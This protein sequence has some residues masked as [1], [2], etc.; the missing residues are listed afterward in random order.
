MKMLYDVA[1]LDWT[2]LEYNLAFYP[3]YDPAPPQIRPLK[4]P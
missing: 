4:F 3:S 2:V 1:S